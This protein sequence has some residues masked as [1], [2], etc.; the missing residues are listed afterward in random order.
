VIPLVEDKPKVKK[1]NSSRQNK[2]ENQVTIAADD[3]KNK[4]FTKKNK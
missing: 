2:S 3:K 1:S 4:T